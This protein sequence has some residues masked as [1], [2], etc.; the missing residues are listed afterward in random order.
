MEKFA[1]IIPDRQ[2]RPEFLEHCLFQMDRQTVKPG[3]KYIINYRPRS[4]TPDLVTR[5]KRG[6]ELAE[7]DGIDI[8]YIIENDDYYPDDYFEK[9]FIG[10][11]D[12]VGIP[13]THYYHIMTGGH[14]YMTDES[15]KGSSLFCTG[16]RISVL[17]NF[18][19]SMVPG[20]MLDSFL[21]KYAADQ[22]C[23]CNLLLTPAL[24]IGIKHGLGLCPGAG[25]NINFYSDI[26]K[27]HAWLKSQ[28]RPESFDFYMGIKKRYGP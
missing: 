16:L 22:K 27:D 11:Y 20:V 19:W 1:I 26:D 21:W 23:N 10:N 17:K 18:Q 9:N 15:R 6:I 13:F 25:H 2:D 24:P 14:L 8:V 3:C 4:S 7:K 28:V 12:F 5:V